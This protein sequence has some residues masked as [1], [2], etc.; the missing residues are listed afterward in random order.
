MKLKRNLTWGKNFTSVKILIKFVFNCLHFI[1]IPLTVDSV[2]ARQ[3]YELYLEQTNPQTTFSYH[4]HFFTPIFRLSPHKNLISTAKT[5]RRHAR[6]RSVA[7][8]QNALPTSRKTPVEAGRSRRAAQNLSQS[9][10]IVSYFFH[11]FVN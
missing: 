5:L 2:K 9:R 4:Y 6:S 7:H 1:R 10:C 11:T 8:N 3:R